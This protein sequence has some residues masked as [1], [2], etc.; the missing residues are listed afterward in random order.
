MR[1]KFSVRR[2]RCFLAALGLAFCMTFTVPASS[3]TVAA[4]SPYTDVFQVNTIYLMLTSADVGY[5]S[6]TETVTC[7]DGLSHNIFCEV[8]VTGYNSAGNI[9]G[10]NYSAN[11]ASN[12]S[13]SCS[14]TV[15]VSL[16]VTRVRSSGKF[17]GVTR[18]AEAY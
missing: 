5:G 1:R 17:A 4:Y 7:T 12:I 6:G 2:V 11:Q 9:T 10:A 18:I 14:A 13:V 16:G 15:N 8:Y 3:L